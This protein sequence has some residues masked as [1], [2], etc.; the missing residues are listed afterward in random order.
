MVMSSPIR[1]AEE[2]QRPVSLADARRFRH[3]TVILALAPLAAW[4]AWLLW[5]EL[6]LSVE[7]ITPL[8]LGRALEFVAIATAG[9]SLWL[10]ILM[11]SGA[12]SYFFHPRALPIVLQNRAVALSYY[13]CAPLAW[14][15]IPAA[16]LLGAL[17]PY[18]KIGGF[19]HNIVAWCAVMAGAAAGLILLS[20]WTGT[21]RVLRH[22]TG[23]GVGR[24]V[25]LA[26]YLPFA[27]AALFVI[28]CAITACVVFVCLV[29]LSYRR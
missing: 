22:A 14:T 1:L 23:C 15:F 9:F 21:I 12:A 19:E 8:D 4:G 11:A 25:A 16:I 27:C 24:A 13:A 18:E 2:V 10:F 29:I 28:C 17:L 26:V 6:R 5:R 3:V 20:F 7:L